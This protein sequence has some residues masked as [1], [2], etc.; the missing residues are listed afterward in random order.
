MSPPGHYKWNG[1]LTARVD[2]GL[3]FFFV[4]NEYDGCCA[5]FACIAPALDIF[6]IAIGIWKQDSGICPAELFLKNGFG[7]VIDL[8][9]TLGNKKCL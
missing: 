8:S 4:G 3:D 1:V 2:H 7:F 5:A 6:F 9:V